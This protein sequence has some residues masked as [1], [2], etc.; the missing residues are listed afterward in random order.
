MSES[1]GLS[2]VGDELPLAVDG[3]TVDSARSV[4]RLK[5]GERDCERIIQLE[6]KAAQ[7]RLTDGEQA[8]LGGY[9]QVAVF[10]EFL[11][12]SARR[13][14]SRDEDGGRGVKPSSEQV[15]FFKR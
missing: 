7:T 14:L 11:K 4:L 9:E 5:F 13:F 1:I 6:S 8:E 3:W 12:R 10:L 2:N 15:G